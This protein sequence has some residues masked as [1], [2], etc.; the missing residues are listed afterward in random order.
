MSR[1]KA[2][3]LWKRGQASYLPSTKEAAVRRVQG[4]EKVREVASALGVR[5]GRIYYWLD[6][7]RSDGGLWPGP[8]GRRRRPKV[9][10]EPGSAERQAELERLL[11]QKQLE[12]D[13]FRQALRS[14]EEARRPIAGHSVPPSGGS[15]Q[16]GRTDRKAD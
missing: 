13:F 11:G 5:P 1:G 10:P 6:R 7:F 16:P 12:L 14:I 3:E 15:L 2:G 8:R 9:L 4:G